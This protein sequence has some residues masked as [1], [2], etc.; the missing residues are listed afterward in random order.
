MESLAPIIGMAMVSFGALGLL[1]SLG[2]LFYYNW[3]R[4]KSK[5]KTDSD[6]AGERQP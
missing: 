4:S 1:A 5:S 2:A 6:A 3:P